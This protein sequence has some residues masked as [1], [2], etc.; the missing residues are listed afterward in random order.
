MIIPYQK[1]TITI[2]LFIVLIFGILFITQ[3]QLSSEEQ[4]VGQS[5]ELRRYFSPILRTEQVSFREGYLRFQLNNSN[6][7]RNSEKV[8]IEE[9]A[10]Q[11]DEEYQI[12]YELGI[13]SFQETMLEFDSAEIEYS[14]IPEDINRQFYYYISYDYS[15]TL[16]VIQTGRDRFRLEFPDT[17][18][19]ISGSK[20]I[21]VSV[22][23]DEDFNIHQS[24][25]LRID[26][27]LRR[28]LRIRAQL[29]DSQSPLTPEGDTRELSS[30]DQIYIKL[31][32]NEYEISFGDLDIA[33]DDT[34]FMNYTSR[35]EGLKAEWF[36][37]NSFQGALAISRGKESSNEFFGK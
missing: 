9:K 37:K 34:Q 30:L 24:L 10:L 27:E 26:G 11:R 25:F 13:I 3:S 19:N 17:Q 7:I 12:D 21:T 8:Y 20:T 2:L 29:S 31:Y 5:T 23:S 1:N 33:F 16:Q 35:F 18:L 32:G 6:I 36:G 14:I 22:A 15:D 28:N 4:E